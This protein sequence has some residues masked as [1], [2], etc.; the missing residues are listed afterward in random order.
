MLRCCGIQWT[1]GVRMVLDKLVKIGAE[2][3]H[4]IVVGDLGLVWPA[5]MVQGMI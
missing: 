5:Y 3:E 1:V 4:D 2:L